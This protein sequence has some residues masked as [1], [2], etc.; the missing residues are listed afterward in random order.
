MKYNYLILLF[1]LSR[2]TDVWCSES[3]PLLPKYLPNSGETYSS[4]NLGRGDQQSTSTT[5]GTGPLGDPST[6]VTS[7]LSSLSL[8]HGIT[9]S[10]RLGVNIPYN[11]VHSTN[12]TGTSTSAAGWGSPSLISS[13]DILSSENELFSV[14][15]QFVPKVGDTLFTRNQS[16]YLLASYS[17]ALED[18]LWGTVVAAYVA[19][20]GTKPDS[21]SITANLAK[22]MGRYSTSFGISASRTQD[23]HLNSNSLSERTTDWSLNAG[24]GGQF[25]RQWDWTVRYIHSLARTYERLDSGTGYLD[26]KT[27]AGFLQ[28]SLLN[29]F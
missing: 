9:D 28:I 3:L 10:F 13:Q 15:L 23:S 8:L 29:R 16:T 18:G 24:I 20:P 27:T 26:S 22:D 7:Y 6:K 17:R 21:T 1:A 4:F 14:G 11:D 12:S 2:T 25:N 5:Y 19:R